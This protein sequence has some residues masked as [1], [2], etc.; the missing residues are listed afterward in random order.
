MSK[1][2]FKIEVI[3][4]AMGYELFVPYCMIVNTGW[5]KI[6]NQWT[7][8]LRTGFDEP[9]KFGDLVPAHPRYCAWED[10]A[11]EAI[12]DFIARGYKQPDKFNRSIE[13]KT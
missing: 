9:R 2:K 13:V 4:S 10:D 7:E 5:R 11:R 6:F 1:Y 8:I 12:N 3:T